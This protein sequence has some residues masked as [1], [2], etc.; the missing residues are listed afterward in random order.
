MSDSNI[1]VP[2][3]L[4]INYNKC[5]SRQLKQTNKQC[6]NFK[7]F[8]SLCKRC[9]QRYLTKGILN[10]VI[11]IPSLLEK[12]PQQIKTELLSCIRIQQWFRKQ[13]LFRI[14]KLRGPARINRDIC[15]NDTDFYTCTPI[16]D[17]EEL[18]FFS[19]ADENSRVFGF[20]IRSIVTLLK[21]STINPYNTCEIP[22]SI[23]SQIQ[24]LWNH[25]KQQLIY[26][27]DTIVYHYGL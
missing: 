3:T 6:R 20:D 15:I 27:S 8:H 25:T 1:V 9:Y 21:Y 10:T 11:P 4:V 5:L 24:Y 7:K 13:Q 17:I 12:S 2:S 26:I 14:Y 23:Q 18:Y 22:K 19:Y 16:K